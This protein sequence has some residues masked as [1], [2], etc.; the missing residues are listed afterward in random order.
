M[1]AFRKLSPDDIRLCRV[2]VPASPTGK[3]VIDFLC[4][5]VFNLS[6]LQD[7]TQE[8]ISKG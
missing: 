4:I 8:E 1:I 6:W 3:K 5:P 7:Q 2:E